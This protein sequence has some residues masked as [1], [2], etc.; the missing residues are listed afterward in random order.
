MMTDAT[1]T[2]EA[3]LSAMQQPV[4]P[5]DIRRAVAQGVS[6]WG[7]PAVRQMGWRNVALPGVLRRA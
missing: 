3:Q 2:I 5:D 6:D 4:K 7:K 1:L